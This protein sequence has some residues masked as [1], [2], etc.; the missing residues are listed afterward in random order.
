MII[1]LTRT[2]ERDTTILV[3]LF[4]YA[5]M[6]INLANINMAI[7]ERI[8]DSL[9]SFMNW[10]DKDR[11]HYS[12]FEIKEWSD[13]LMYEYEKVPVIKKNLKGEIF[14]S[15]TKYDYP[16]WIITGVDSVEKIENIRERT[17]CVL[18]RVRVKIEDATT[19]FAMGMGGMVKI[20]YPSLDA[21]DDFINYPA[22][23]NVALHHNIVQ[24][25][26]EIESLLLHYRSIVS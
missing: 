26:M 21:A 3:K 2:S 7:S 23:Y 6:K 19:A 24:T 13:E 4:Q 9:I 22:N 14:E 1:A 17:K 15:E 8:E 16:D 10:P 12:N 25:V 18:F 20:Q 5:L 11:T